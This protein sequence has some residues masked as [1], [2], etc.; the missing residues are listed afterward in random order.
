MSSFPAHW[1]IAALSNIAF[2]Q[3]GQSPNS[4]SYNQRGEGLPFFQG[5]AEFGNLF[6][7]ARK[8]CTEPK[9]VAAEGDILLSVRA[10]VGPTNMASEEC[11]IGRGLAAI[12]SIK[13]LD[14][15]Y[16]LYYFRNIEPWLSL[17]GKGSTFSA[18][19]S[20][21]IRSLSIPIAPLSEQKRIAEKL[22]I[23]MARLNKCRSRL[24]HIPLILTHFRK[25]V[26]LSGM[27]GSLTDDWRQEYLEGAHPQ[28][29]KNVEKLSSIAD[30]IDPNPS[31]RYPSYVGGTIPL[32]A[33]G[34]MSGLDDWDT[35]S[36]KLAT[37]DFYEKRKEAHGLFNND[38]IFA[39][40]GRL[41]L[42]RNP[43]ASTPCV[44]SHTVFI[45]RSTSQKI[46]PQYLLWFLRQEKCIEWLLLE[47]N[48]NAGVPTLGKAVLERLPI[49][50]PDYL[51]QEEIVRR[52]E[53]LYAYADQLEDHYK[54]ALRQIEQI[55][56]A[57]LSKAFRGEL[58]SRDTTEEPASVILSQIIAER[59]K[60]PVQEIKTLSYR[61]SKMRKM[62]RKTVKA[63]VG[64]W[65]QDVFSFEAL[66]K[67]VYSKLSGDYDTLKDILFTLL[68]E[69]SPVVKQVFDAELQEIRFVKERK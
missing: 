18:I 3:M 31:H 63:L 24:S 37:L 62:S 58:V 26:I 6:P 1:A 23:L 53:K 69:S 68:D 34:Q 15:K 28:K 64:E 25:A 13:P 51:E 49:E 4:R 29:E 2:I 46:S 20:S 61:E 50:M 55:E 39:R 45:I 30:V 35:S 41:G 32:L 65:Q 60:N 43:P 19:N 67:E 57:L 38:I 36:A 52:I 7:M 9:K 12:Q 33:T 47:M 8:W 27:S 5:K 14:Q 56:S 42:A 16:L 17:Q 11:C 44:F 66:N 48:S 10:P 40:K 54:S 22:D 21:F 59:A